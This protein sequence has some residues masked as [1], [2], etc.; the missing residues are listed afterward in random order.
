LIFTEVNR[1]NKAGVKSEN[2]S[3]QKF[4]ILSF[5]DSSLMPFYPCNRLQQT[6]YEDL[7]TYQPFIMQSILHTLRLFDVSL[8]TI[9]KLLQPLGE[10]R[11][12]QRVGI[13]KCA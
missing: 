5:A 13:N 2:E 9:F 6:F 3:R 10:L 12:L 4:T 8:E 11:N 7:T 1:N